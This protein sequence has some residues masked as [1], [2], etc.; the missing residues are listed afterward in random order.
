MKK[1]HWKYRLL[2]WYAKHILRVPI[3]VNFTPDH[4]D[5]LFGVG[6]AWSPEASRRMQGDSYL[7]ERMQKAEAAAVVAS[8]SRKARKLVNRAARR[9]A[10]RE[11]RRAGK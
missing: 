11:L 9:Q 5:E 2:L 7:L 4:M 3:I 1:N 8:G 10:E 6:F